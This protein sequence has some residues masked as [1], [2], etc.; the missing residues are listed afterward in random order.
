MECDRKARTAAFKAQVALAAV[1]G[2]RALSELAAYYGAHRT[3]I[4]AWKRQLLAGAEAMFAG[5]PKATELEKTLLLTYRELRALERPALLFMG[6]FALGDVYP[7]GLKG[8]LSSRLSPNDLDILFSHA[9][10]PSR[11]LRFRSRVVLFHPCGVPEYLKAEFL[12]VYI[13]IVKKLVSLSFRRKMKAGGPEGALAPDWHY[14]AGLSRHGDSSH[15]ANPDSSCCARF[16][17]IA[18]SHDVRISRLSSRTER[19]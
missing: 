5:G 14:R 4:D 1:K 3:L 19:P 12:G 8:L 17:E 15:I 2:D 13:R 16:R 6:R 7:D 10:S 9:N 11:P 18:N